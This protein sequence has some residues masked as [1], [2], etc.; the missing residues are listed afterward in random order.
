MVVGAIV[1]TCIKAGKLRLGTG[2]LPEGVMHIDI[3]S[4]A[5]LNSGTIA[6]IVVCV[7]MMLFYLFA[8]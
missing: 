7:G 2:S 4:A 5:Y 6:F 3:A 1:I 8:S